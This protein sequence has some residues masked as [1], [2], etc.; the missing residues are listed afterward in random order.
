MPTRQL[1]S[2]DEGEYTRK[3]AKNSSIRVIIGAL[4]AVIVIA[5]IIIIY[6]GNFLKNTSKR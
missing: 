4:S 6:K 5:V 1:D 2:D 3:R